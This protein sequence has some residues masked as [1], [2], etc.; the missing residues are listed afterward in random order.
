[1]KTTIANFYLEFINNYLTIDKFASVHDMAYDDAL[2]LL[3]LGKNF[4][5]ER[6]AIYKN[7]GE[8]A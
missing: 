4:H 8:T 3:A 7:I 2:L 5:E 6:V 1:M